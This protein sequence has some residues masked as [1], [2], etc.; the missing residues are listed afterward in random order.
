MITR[1]RP[2][3]AFFIAGVLA[4]A[5]RAAERVDIVWPTPNPAWANGKPLVDYV[6]HAG[7]GEVESGTFGGVRSGGTHFH[8]G[9]DMKCLARDRRGEPLDNVFA[10]MSGVV[11]HINS[12]A[13]DSNYGRYVVLE[14]P[15]QAPAV[16]TLYAHLAR[17]AP[18][19]REGAVVTRGQVLGTMGHS[20][21]G[22]MIPVDRAHL[23]FEI[24]LMMTRD[25]EAWYGRKNSGSRN[26]HGAWNGMNLMGV[27]PLEFLNAWRAHR[28]DTFQDYFSRLPT[29][30]KLRIATHRVPDFI[31]RYPS[32]LTK[33]IPLGGVAGWEIRCNWTGVPFAWTPLSP[34]DVMGLPTDQPRIAEVDEVIIRR[35]RSKSIAVSHRGGWVVGKDLETVLQQ[36]FGVR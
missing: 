2:I 7:S 30:V 12:S 14:H 24:G 18:G 17:I 4:V 1:A 32:L 33:P 10:G 26:D 27:D 35:E 9:I 22:Y 3:Q 20:S 19:L 34:P 36:L 15:E 11:R 13:G 21:G 8:E 31:T 5:S 29:A 25:F 6:Q 23:H 28:V 16:Y